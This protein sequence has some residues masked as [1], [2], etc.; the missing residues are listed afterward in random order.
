MAQKFKISK[1]TLAT[2]NTRF[3]N[4]I[5]DLVILYLISLSIYFISTFIPFNV[6]YETFADWIHSLDNTQSYLYGSFLSFTYYSITESLLSRSIAKYF[7]KTIV[8]LEDG[9]KPKTIDI[10]A[11]SILRQV[12][13][14]HF[15]FLHGRKPGLHDEYSKTFVVK[16]EKLEKNIRDFQEIVNH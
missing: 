9:T 8:I 14:E 6:N 3:I 1:Y 11:R 12:P 7:T 16:K 4:F 10:L 2:K 15:T 13:L 5:I